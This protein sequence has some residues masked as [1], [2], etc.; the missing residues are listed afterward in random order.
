MQSLLNRLVHRWNGCLRVEILSILKIT[1]NLSNWCI[2]KEYIF[3]WYN[4]QAFCIAGYRDIT[5]G[6]RLLEHLSYVDRL[7]D[8]YWKLLLHLLIYII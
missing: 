8:R 7:S 3:I 2:D 5:P 6:S 1:Y 4:F